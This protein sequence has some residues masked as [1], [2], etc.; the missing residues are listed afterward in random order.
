[1]GDYGSLQAI[2]LAS[3]AQIESYGSLWA[4][5]GLL[6]NKGGDNDLFLAS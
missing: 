1:M 2:D 6:G 4:D 3:I 5:T